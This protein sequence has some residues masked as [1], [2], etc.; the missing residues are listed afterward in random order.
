[1]PVTGLAVSPHLRAWSSA[2]STWRR[3][4]E[5]GHSYRFAAVKSLVASVSRCA[6]LERSN[7]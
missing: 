1:M 6:F 4:A 7:L 3:W 5:M 2:G